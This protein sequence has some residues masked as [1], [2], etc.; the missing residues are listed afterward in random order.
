MVNS[1]EIPEKNISSTIWFSNATSGYLAEEN[2]NT[3]LKRY[4]HPMLITELLT[5]AKIWKQPWCPLMDE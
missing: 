2:E 4:I 3:T 1:T 5:I